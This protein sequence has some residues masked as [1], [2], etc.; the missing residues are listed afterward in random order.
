MANGTVGPDLNDKVQCS[1]FITTSL[2]SKDLDITQS[3]HCSLFCPGFYTKKTCLFKPVHVYAI[4]TDIQMSEP[5]SFEG[6]CI[7]GKWSGQ[8]I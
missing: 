8:N 2:Y 6:S 1:T 5:V 4:S 7:A 3:C